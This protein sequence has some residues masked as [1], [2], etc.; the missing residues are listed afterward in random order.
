MLT[1]D[2]DLQEIG[3]EII[4]QAVEEN[5]AFGGDLLITDPNTGAILAMASIRDGNTASLSAIS[6]PYEPGST[7]KPIT[8]AGILDRGLLSLDD[9]VDI[10]E[11][12][13]SVNGR[14]LTDVGSE[15][16]LDDLHPD[17]R[18]D[19][20]RDRRERSQH[21]HVGRPGLS[22]LRSDVVCR[23]DPDVLYQIL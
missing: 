14:V 20:G 2:L 11:G 22:Q 7:L 8:V 3:E 10:E 6:T 17:F 4:A 12:R 5:Q 1:L 18:P 16:G 21:D 19:L 23:H 13:W 9:S 15:S